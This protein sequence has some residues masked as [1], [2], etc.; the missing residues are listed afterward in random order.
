MGFYRSKHNNIKNQWLTVIFTTVFIFIPGI[1]FSANPSSNGGTEEERWF[2]VELI[3]FAHRNKEAL[4]SEDWPDISGLTLPENLVEL[5]FPPPE[6]EEKPDENPVKTEPGLIFEPVTG[7]AVDK[8]SG[9]GDGTITRPLPMPVAFEMLP[10]QEL[11]LNNAMKK[12]SRSS[13]FEPLLHIAWRQPTYDREHAQSVLLYQGMTDS[14]PEITETALPERK[15]ND[16]RTLTPDF[17]GNEDEDVS[18]I[19]PRVVGT[20]RVSVARYL[21]FSADLVYRTQVLERVA[22]PLSDLELWDDKPYPTLEERQ[23]PAYQLESWNVMRGFRLEE[24]RRMRS[25]KIHYLDHPFFGV[26]V[27]ITPVELPESPDE[28]MTPDP[29]QTNPSPQQ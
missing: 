8:I 17:I 5:T 9:T 14:V 19:N 4:E 7:Q 18:P 21:H 16:N 6:Q 25:R 24:S 22:V 26:V 2:Q 15:Q 3:V 1:V 23:G 27:L 20:V 28:E 11:Q 12:I 13:R 10:E 29:G